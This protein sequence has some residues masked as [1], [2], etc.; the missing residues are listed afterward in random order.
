MI[1]YGNKYTSKTQILKFLKHKKDINLFMGREDVIID[2]RDTLYRLF[3]AESIYRIVKVNKIDIKK[4]ENPLS[5]FL[6]EAIT[7]NEEVTFCFI[8]SER[9]CK[10]SNLKLMLDIKEL[11]S[12]VVCNKLAREKFSLL[13]CF[14]LKSKYFY[15]TE[16]LI[17]MLL[18]NTLILSNKTNPL[19]ND[20]KNI[21]L[22]YNLDKEL[23]ITENEKEIAKI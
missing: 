16:D 18:N 23:N 20:I 11:E 6:L 2:Y 17:E 21:M 7:N 13:N 9:Y 14:A 1:Y 10:N 22:Y 15:D 8:A 5:S 12:I 19:I 3:H 4:T